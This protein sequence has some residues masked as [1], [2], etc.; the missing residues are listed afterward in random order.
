METMKKNQE[1]FAYYWIVDPNVEEITT[2]RIYGI[3]SDKKN[4]CLVVDNF[5]PFC[6]VELP[7]VQVSASIQTT[8]KNQCISSELV[9]RKHLYNVF[10]TD[11]LSPFLYCRCASK[12]NIY[13]IVYILSK[14]GVF[15]SGYGKIKLKVHEVEASPILQ[16]ISVKDLYTAGWI[17]FSGK[18]IAEDD[19]NT[20]CDLEYKVSWKNLH[21]METKM[22]N[23]FPKYC[24]FDIEVNSDFITQMPS[25]RP[26]DVIFQI[27]CVVE[28]ENKRRKFL[29]TFSDKNKDL[30]TCELLSSVSVFKFETEEDLLLNFLQFIVDERPNVITG[31]NILGF[32][33][34]YIIK[35]CNRLFLINELK[36]IGFN[37]ESL[38][39]EEKIKWTSSA[40]KNQEFKFINWEGILLLDLLPIIKRD[41]KLD[42]YSLKKV[43]KVFLKNEVKDPITY[44]EIFES[45]RTRTRLDEVGKYCV[46][47]SNLCIELLNHLH[48]WISL[49]EMAKVCNVSMFT[50][51]TQGQQIKTYSQVYKYCLKE[52]I[53]VDTN[54]YETKI[55]ERYTGAYVFEPVPDIYDKVVPFD[56]S[57]LYPSIIIAKNICYSTLVENKAI[58]DSMC[59]VFE[60]EDHVGCIHDDNIIE[61]NKLTQDI[62]LIGDKIKMLQQKRDA[63]GSLKLTPFEKKKIQAEINQM[64]ISQKPLRE[65]RQNLKKS[66]PNDREDEDGNKI[67][68][69][70]CEKRY[71]RFYKTEVKKG[72]IPTIIQ[73][74][75]DSRARVKKQMK[76]V[77][78]SIALILDKEQNAYKI[79]ANSMYGAMGVRK[80]YLPLMPGAMCVTYFG[81]KSIELAA[82]EIVKNWKGQLIYGDTDSNY[83]I[84]PHLKT[85]QEIWDYAIKTAEQVSKIFPPPM[86][87]E[88]EQTIYDRFLILS[89]KR[90]IYQSIDRN[91][92][93]NLQVGKKGVVLSRRDNSKFVR[94][95]YEKLS[96]LI[97][98]KTSKEKIVE[99]VLDYIND[100]YRNIF[101]YDVYVITKSIG[102]TGG[103][104]GLVNNNK[105]GEYKIRNMA[106][107]ENDKNDNSRDFYISQ[108]P[109]H[110]Q[111]SEKMRKRGCPISTGSRIE[112][113][114]I[115]KPSFKTLADRIEDYDYFLKRS[116][117]LRIDPE[118]YLYSLINPLDQ[119][120]SI[121]IHNDHFVKDQY[122]IRRQYEKVNESIKNLGRAK[123]KIYKKLS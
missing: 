29:F 119:L 79:S 25:D 21:K 120:L 82:Q 94:D 58:P 90:Y 70:I 17:N 75:L 66:K 47:D 24:A 107:T 63:K 52:K 27:S 103:E 64:R 73:N 92:V 122:N 9:F 40:Y 81:R 91:G 30:N 78:A 1:M 53:I 13:S 88:F 108:C 55:N 57:S 34:E 123:I 39:S 18:K 48:S 26:G 19:M 76:N 4:V 71:Y 33:I 97:F 111:L 100:L 43:A 83:V 67:E 80:G 10:N 31:F 117:I 74:L 112:F 84:F 121:G 118:Y 49:S 16:L 46:Q 5:T 37:R 38:A 106:S 20:S 50:L 6:Y 99:F 41:Y 11:E 105:L 69:V 60:W 65:K 86:K 68:N 85:V 109:A 87:L 8:I 115:K 101:S 116:D 32:D 102:D 44:R 77:D 2:I 113:V 15:L 89:K 96:M 22:D 35:R 7:N 45:Y 62:N 42:T 14:C 110:V 114:V 12:K 59:N 36:S 54:G 3:N 56:F 28:Q 23:A 104:D 95:I 98:Q 93:L 72:V 51:Y 61:I